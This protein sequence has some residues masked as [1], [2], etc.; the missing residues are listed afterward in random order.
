MAHN[1]TLRLLSFNFRVQLGV[2]TFMDYDM[3]E[4]L[5]TFFTPESINLPVLY[6]VY[7]NPEDIPWEMWRGRLSELLTDKTLRTGR[8]M[9]LYKPKHE[10]RLDG[11]YR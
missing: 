3:K 5:T 4:Q 1:Y 6:D 2:S 8:F 9:W 7:C 10:G 11:G